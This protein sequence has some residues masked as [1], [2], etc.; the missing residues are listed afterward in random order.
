MDRFLSRN[1]N[2]LSLGLFG[3]FPRFTSISKLS[4]AHRQSNGVAKNI[5]SDPAHEPKN[6]PLHHRFLL[7]FLSNRYR[8]HHH[9]HHRHP[10]N[11]PRH[12]IPLYQW[13]VHISF[14]YPHLQNK[15]L[16]L[17]EIVLFL[18]LLRLSLIPFGDC[19]CPFISQ[20][21]AGHVILM[22]LKSMMEIVSYLLH[23]AD[24]IRI[25]NHQFSIYDDPSNSGFLFV[26]CYYFKSMS[27]CSCFSLSTFFVLIV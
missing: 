6:Y 4:P 7:P 3:N 12:P 23:E 27:T 8:H 17:S 20:V 24:L 9:C 13:L 1:L 26:L 5:V 21:R 15:Q 10:C 18:L 22:S 2:L 25:S 19:S 11:L 14:P 16:S